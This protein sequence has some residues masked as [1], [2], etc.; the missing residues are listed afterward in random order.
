[1]TRLVPIGLSG[2][3]IKLQAS[4]LGTFF[5]Y[6]L[7]LSMLIFKKKSS[8]RFRGIWILHKNDFLCNTQSLEQFPR[9]LCG[10]FFL[11]ISILSPKV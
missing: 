1:M 7:G 4:K 10:D 6:T 5:L 2:T 3:W 8:P 9:N 11:K